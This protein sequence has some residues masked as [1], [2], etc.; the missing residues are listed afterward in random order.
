[1]HEST[2]LARSLIDSV[3]A[4]LKEL[5]PVRSTDHICVPSLTHSL[6]TGELS[7]AR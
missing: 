4:L 3:A 2:L 1:M 5:T 6:A 7:G